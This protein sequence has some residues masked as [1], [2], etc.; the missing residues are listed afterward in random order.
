MQPILHVI[1]VGFDH[2]KGCQVEFCYPPFPNSAATSNPDQDLPSAWANLP[3]LAIPDQCHTSTADTV[4]FTIPAVENPNQTVF[5]ISCYRQ[6]ESND[7]LSKDESMTRNYVQKSV[8]VLSTIPLFGTLK[9]KLEL[10]T[11]S[12]F[13]EKDFSKASPTEERQSLILF[14][15]QVD[16]L[17]QMH[18]NLTDIF[19]GPSLDSIYMGVAL[20]P[21]LR[22]FKHRILELI[23][24]VLLE[25]KIIFELHPTNVLSDVMIGLASLFPCLIESGLFESAAY[26]AHDHERKAEESARVR[27]E[28]GFPL[29]IFTK[30]NIFLPYQSINGIDELRN[31]NVRGYCIGVTNGIYKLNQDLY[32]VYVTVNR[33]KKGAALIEYNSGE[34]AQKVALTTQDTRFMNSILKTA[35]DAKQTPAEF[36]GNDDWICMQLYLYL[37]S[38]FNAAT[39]GNEHVPE[40]NAEFIRLW[41]ETHNF[42]GHEKLAQISSIHPSAGPLS[43]QDLIALVGHQFNHFGQNH[44]VMAT[45][46]TAGKY[47]SEQS[48]RL[49][50][51]FSSWIHRS[52]SNRGNPPPGGDAESTKVNG[53]VSGP[54]RGASPLD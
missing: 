28:H 19:D 11:Q 38:M 7:L 9:D 32:D 43:A 1:V 44:A 26:V 35:A 37:C 10:I 47:L 48:S 12:Y 41:K 30:G 33:P 22:I 8:C 45:L 31:P 18:S 21:L 23:K 36:N 13:E 34:L 20:E 6:I 27:N 29:Q 42:Q 46:S 15:V 3:T 25:R 16:V 52:G 53:G 2:K 24:L 40:Y 51:T 5:G 39:K 50:T 17:K 14:L 54:N 49:R 4:F